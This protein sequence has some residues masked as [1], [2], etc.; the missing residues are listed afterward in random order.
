M[1]NVAILIGRLGSDPELSYTPS[2]KAVCKFSLAT[3]SGKDQ[4]DWHNIVAWEQQAENCAK[5]LAKGKVACVEGRITSRSW[6]DKKTGEKKYIT[7]I[8]AYSVV[9]LSPKDESPYADGRPTPPPKFNIPARGPAAK[10]PSL[11]GFDDET[12]PF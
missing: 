2:Q 4:T 8:I 1:K 9:F 5:F 3:T 12:I 7:E 10:M 11:D 6:D